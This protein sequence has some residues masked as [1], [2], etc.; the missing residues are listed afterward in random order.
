MFGRK[1]ETKTEPETPESK[2]ADAA[3]AETAASNDA[4]DA[5]QNLTDG[6]S[7]AH[8]HAAPHDGIAG[9]TTDTPQPPIDDVNLDRAET[10]HAPAP[11]AVLGKTPQ[12]ERAEDALQAD[13]KDKA[14]HGEG[15]HSA[16][17]RATQGGDTADAKIAGKPKTQLQ[18]LKDAA[19][20]AA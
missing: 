7:P 16:S 2:A 3:R 11:D 9:A 18:Q 17:E 1:P 5:G 4:P 15:P 14:Q 20:D 6:E 19:K 13:A 12:Q 10:G 8:T